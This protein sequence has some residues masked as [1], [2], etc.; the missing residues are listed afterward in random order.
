MKP[1]IVGPDRWHYKLGPNERRVAIGV[2]RMRST[3]SDGTDRIPDKCTREQRSEN[4]VYACMAE[5]AV[6]KMM[7][8]CWTGIER[9]AVDVGGILE[10]RM[11]RK[12][13]YGLLARAEDTEDAPAV[14]VFVDDD[15]VCHAMGW[16]FFGRVRE[17]G[18]LRDGETK[19]PYWVT[20]KLR[21]MSTLFKTAQ[22]IKQYETSEMTHRE[23]DAA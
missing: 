5:I 17:H 14:L 4:D 18:T 15:E 7:N 6:A 9:R 21:P 11:V 13:D 20:K 10:V 8:L 23:E 22:W 1:G 3:E 2:A 19:Y 16:E 12:K